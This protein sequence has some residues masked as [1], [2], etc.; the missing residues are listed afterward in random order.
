VP[1]GRGDG[2]HFLD[3]VGGYEFVCFE[4]RGAESAF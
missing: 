3:C 4:E 2:G 1:G